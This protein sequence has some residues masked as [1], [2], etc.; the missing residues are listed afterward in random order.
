MGQAEDGRLTD[1]RVLDEDLL[2]VDTHGLTPVA[3]NT[4]IKLQLELAFIDLLLDI[5]TYLLIDFFV[6]PN[7][8]GKKSG[9]PELIFGVKFFDQQGNLFLISRLV[10]AFIFPTFSDTEYLGGIIITR[11]I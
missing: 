4:K 11:W 9:G 1:R 3:L 5:G 2:D 10:L 8:G 7:G 6:D